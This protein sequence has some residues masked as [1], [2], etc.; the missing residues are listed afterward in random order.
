[1]MIATLKLSSLI[2]RFDRSCSYDRKHNGA[3]SKDYWKRPID[4]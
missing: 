2:D 4:G 1:M 3:H